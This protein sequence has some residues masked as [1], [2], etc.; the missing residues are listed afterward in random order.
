MHVPESDVPSWTGLLSA[1]GFVIGLP[2]LPFW[3]VWAD[4]WGRKLIII[5]SAVVE[6]TIFLLAAWSKNV[7]MLAFARFLS[8]FVLGNTGVMMAVQAEI[9]PG[10]RL[11]RAIAIVSAGAPVGMALGPWLGGL[12]VKAWGI[13]TLLEVDAA[14]TVLVAVMLAL[15]FR[16]EP[17]KQLVS[18]STR[19]GVMTAMRSI[20][21]SPAVLALFGAVFAMM[22]GISLS[23]P[24]VPILIKQLYHGN[25]LAPTIGAVLTLSGVAMA[26]ATPFWGP[27]GD[28]M[29]HL[30]ALRFCAGMVAITLVAQCF[31]QDVANLGA[32]RIGMGLCQGGLSALGMT[33]L[34]KYASPEKRSS[35]LTMS[36]L[37]HQ[38]A[39]F[40]GPLAG[41]ALSRLSITAP[42]MA[43]AVCLLFGALSVRN[44]EGV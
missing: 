22:F 37:P 16:E 36:L 12:V 26:V 38:M 21:Q 9:T 30:H 23:M 18:Q 42:F 7:W 27:I 28:R 43:G 13:R 8:G 40:L 10:D 15:F 6:A 1:L 3:G 33:L 5:R 44:R 11:G 2:L 29:G 25:N 39:W 17:R 34:A 31:S 32:W 4:R 19:E 41:A 35:V 14:L 20:V 24:Y